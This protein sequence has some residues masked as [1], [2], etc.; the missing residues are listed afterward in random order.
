[1]AKISK[2]YKAPAR[3]FSVNTND[4]NFLCVVGHHINGSYIAILNWGVS[5]ELSAFGDVGYNTERIYNAFKTNSSCKVL[6]EN[7][8]REIA[9]SINE[10]TIAPQQPPEEFF[11]SI[12]GVE[13]SKK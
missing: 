6:T 4:Y 8:A 5:A 10:Y 11:K 3:E 2:E 7:I 12:M 9:E 1:M 13:K